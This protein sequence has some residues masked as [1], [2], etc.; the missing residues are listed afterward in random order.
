MSS[1][2]LRKTNTLDSDSLLTTNEVIDLYVE[3]RKKRVSR[4]NIHDLY[5]RKKLKRVNGF[6]IREEVVAYLEGLNA[7]DEEM[8]GKE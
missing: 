8:K 2:L 6:Y 4:Q 5:K 3:I 1:T 7:L